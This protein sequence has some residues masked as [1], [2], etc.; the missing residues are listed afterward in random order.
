MHD[1]LII[2]DCCMASGSPA[3][4]A[5]KSHKESRTEILAA[6]GFDKVAAAG[7]AHEFTALL[8]R[9]ICELR[10][11]DEQTHSVAQ[12]HSILLSRMNLHHSA[13][14]P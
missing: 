12:I 6:C 1:A 7:G 9:T 14:D 13:R 3:F 8:T 10:D 11:I 5:D 4:I 2:L